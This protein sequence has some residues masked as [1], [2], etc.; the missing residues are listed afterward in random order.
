[1]KKLILTTAVT[2]AAVLIF[3]NITSAESTT[4]DF[5]PTIKTFYWLQAGYY[6]NDLENGEPTFEFKR[7]RFGIKGKVLKHV[8]YH[9]MIEGIHD[10]VDPRVYQ[11]WIDYELHPLASVRVGQFKYP[12]GLEALPG[13]VWWKFIDPSLV[14]GGI[15]KELGRKNAAD[16]TGLFRDIGVQL[17]GNYKI[18]ENYTAKYQAMIMNGNGILKTDNNKAKDFAIRG[19]LFAPYGAQVGIAYFIGNFRNATDS[20][21]YDE[22]ALGL[23][24]MLENKLAGRPFRVQGEYITAVYETT[25]ADLKPDGYYIYGTYCLYTSKLEAAIRYANYEPTSSLTLKKTTAGLTWYIAKDQLIRLNVD[26]IDSDAADTE[27][28]LN[29]IF[30]ITL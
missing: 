20:L 19:Q 1:M 8:G 12:F 14:T 16:E 7:A 2:F 23:E 30:Q 15:V 11:A 6:D 5:K 28:K 21:D 26:S 25:S 13:F 17:S 10:G 27:Y 22:S 3:A 24:F 9:L 4:D 18:N 29:I